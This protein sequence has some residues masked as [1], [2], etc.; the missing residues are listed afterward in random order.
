MSVHGWPAIIDITWLLPAAGHSHAR[1]AAK[2]AVTAESQD[3][4]LAAMLGGGEAS[5]SGGSPAAPA[6]TPQRRAGG[7]LPTSR[8]TPASRGSPAAFT[9]VRLTAYFHMTARMPERPC[10]TV[11]YCRSNAVAPRSF[12]LVSR[13]QQ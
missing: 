4:L 5:F 12:R 6:A 10:V 13:V 1:P 9:P 7:P 11:K 8:H 3:A 2:A